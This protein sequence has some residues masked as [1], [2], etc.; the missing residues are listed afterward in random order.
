MHFH[1]APKHYFGI[2]QLGWANKTTARKWGRDLYGP[3]GYRILSC[4]ANC[5]V[6]P[7]TVDASRGHY[8]P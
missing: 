2:D 4:S 8:D 3:Y 5:A 6:Y 1:I 7:P